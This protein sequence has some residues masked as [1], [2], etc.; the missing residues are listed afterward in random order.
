M[1][2]EVAAARNDQAIGLI[3]RG[4]GPRDADPRS[5]LRHFAIPIRATALWRWP[6]AADTD[7]L[8]CATLAGAPTR[9]TISELMIPEGE[10]GSLGR[11]SE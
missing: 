2:N 1:G 6:F 10:F 4:C 9:T 5:A 8:V 3:A 7:Y 11:A